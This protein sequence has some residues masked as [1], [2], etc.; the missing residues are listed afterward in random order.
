M[1]VKRIA[2]WH[3][4]IYGADPDARMLSEEAPA[5][6]QDLLAAVWE[7]GLKPGYA[8]KSVNY[9]ASGNDMIFWAGRR[10]TLDM[11]SERGSYMRPGLTVEQALEMI[12]TRAREMGIVPRTDVGKTQEAR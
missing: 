6:V 9:P 4:R 1:T 12:K 8:K 11:Y 2:P 5:Q 3:W 7:A 10:G